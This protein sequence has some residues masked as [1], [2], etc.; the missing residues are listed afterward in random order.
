VNVNS[1]RSKHLGFS[2]VDLVVTVSIIVLLGGV[3]CAYIANNRRASSRLTCAF[4]L[5]EIR[6]A[7]L[8]FQ[9]DHNDC[10]PWMLST[11]EGGTLEYCASGVQT[12]R[13]YQIESNNLLMSIL[14]VCP[15]DTR[16]AATSFANLANENISY[17][18]DFD[19][20][21]NAPMTIVHGDR[22]ITPD[23][24]V[25]LQ[26]TQSTPPS[27]IKSVGLHGDRG[28]LV[29]SDGHVEELDSAGLASA[30]QRTGIA[31][32]HFAVP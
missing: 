25:I 17:F 26:M 10:Y 2:R 29:F 7:E 22:N 21:P 13:H 31:T 8:E 28:H 14:L 12:F 9:K 1:T 3:V 5:K 23:S 19:S 32:N 4:K 20:K 27:W 18:L 15:Q 24:G 16:T 6:L 11:N 30:V